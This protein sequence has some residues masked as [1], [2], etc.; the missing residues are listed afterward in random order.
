MI[1]QNA[2]G[3]LIE[4]ILLFHDWVNIFVIAIAI[5]TLYT[6]GIILYHSKSIRILIDGQKIEFLWTIFPAIVLFAI[7]IPSLRLLYLTDEVGEIKR[8]VKTIGHQWYWQYEIPS[9]RPYD[10]YILNEKSFRLLE[11]DHNLSTYSIQTTLILVSAADVLHSWTVPTLAVKAD[12]VPG[13]VNKLTII[14]NR[15]GLYYGQCSEICGRNHRFIPITLE[16]HA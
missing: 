5:A 7:V 15:P 9:F 1:F 13:R 10:S 2:A 11:T 12:A 6:I 8:T 4:G 3:P 16:V 14:A